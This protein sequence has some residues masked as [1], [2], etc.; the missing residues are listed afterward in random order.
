MNK[1]LI[2]SLIVF[3]ITSSYGQF[4]S[5][6]YDGNKNPVI[7]FANHKII[8]MPDPNPNGDDLI[9]DLDKLRTQ[10]RKVAES[11]GDLSPRAFGLYTELKLEKGR[12][13]TAYILPPFASYHAHHKE[14]QS[15]PPSW[16]KPPL[17]Y[18]P[19]IKHEITIPTWEE[20]KLVNKTYTT[21]TYPDPYPEIGYHEALR[22]SFI[23][24]V[25]AIL[26]MVDPVVIVI[27]TNPG[28]IMSLSAGTL[29]SGIDSLLNKVEIG[30]FNYIVKDYE[31]LLDYSREPLLGEKNIEKLP[32][33]LQRLLSEYEKAGLKQ[34]F[35]LSL[36]KLR[37]NY[38][39]ASLEQLMIYKLAEPREIYALPIESEDFNRLIDADFFKSLNRNQK[40]DF[41]K[42]RI[43]GYSVEAT[44]TLLKN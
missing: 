31:L 13:N 33:F 18:P 2:L 14:T 10:Q 8:L 24:A 38:P 43:K 32:S 15:I 28:K 9:V 34:T 21:Y 25:R 30:G 1:K 36:E 37:T 19:A 42:Y 26:E 44:K 20:G 27:K 17:F 12:R 35:L 7:T 41:L 4:F 16:P 5:V 40:I 29:E 6:T 39:R 23:S 22:L 3:A 11:E